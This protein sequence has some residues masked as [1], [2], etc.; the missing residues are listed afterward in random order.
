ML[1]VAAE[2]DVS[3]NLH[4]RPQRNTSMP[5]SGAGELRELG[6]VRR[7]S[8]KQTLQRNYSFI[9]VVDMEVR[10]QH[11]ANR[12]VSVCLRELSPNARRELGLIEYSR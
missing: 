2:D 1:E 5:P 9:V 10:D 8:T 12:K 4:E 3:G 11:W 6:C 7:P